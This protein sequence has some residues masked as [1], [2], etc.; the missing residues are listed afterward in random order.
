MIFEQLDLSHDS[1]SMLVEDLLSVNSHDITKGE[2]KN[3]REK[4]RGVGNQ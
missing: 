1:F 3:A 4:K 2:A